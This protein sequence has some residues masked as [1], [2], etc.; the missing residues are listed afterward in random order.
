MN[1][2]LEFYESLDTTAEKWGRVLENGSSTGL[3]NEMVFF[4]ILKHCKY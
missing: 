4:F 1:F 3:I 2:T